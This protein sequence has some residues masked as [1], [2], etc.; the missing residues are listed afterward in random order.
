MKAFSRSPSRRAWP[1]LLLLPL[2]FILILYV[3]PVLNLV[4]ISFS[5]HSLQEAVVPGF[6]IG[7]YARLIQ[8][9][10]YFEVLWRTIR[11]SLLTTLCCAV[12]GYPI[13]FYLTRTSG[14]RQTIMFIVLLM[15]LVTSVTVMSY[16]WLI[17][18]G[19]KGV[20]NTLLVKLGFF[21][22]PRQLMYNETVIVVGLVHILVVFMVIAV[23]A[24]LQSINPALARAARSLGA[25]PFTAFRQIT[26]PLSMPGLRTGAL[27]VFV[28]SMSAYATPTVLGGTRVKFLSYLVYQQA[29]SLN[30]WPRG[31]AMA[32]ILLIATT[33]ILAL[34]SAYGQFRAQR[35]QSASE[36]ATSTMA[37]ER[38][39]D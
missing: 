38:A 35:R 1:I 29:I 15:P 26:L 7:N 4:S 19:R 31:A 3:V 36:M 2:L 37:P 8:D 6:S 11:L 17:L 18:L 33:A 23:A 5:E 28:L 30:N 21:E 32:V 13:A 10:F 9:S 39:G 22:M 27:L 14:W 12:F 34:A 16:G 24:S 25:S 20:V